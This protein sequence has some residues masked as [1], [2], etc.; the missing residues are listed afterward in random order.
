MDSDEDFLRD[1]DAS[2]KAVN[3]FASRMRRRG[4]CMWLPP[5]EVRPDSSVRADYS[6]NGD[7]ILQGRV[8]HKVRTIDFTTRDDYPFPTVIVDEKRIEDGKAEDPV[9][10]YVIEN[11]AGTHAAVVYGWTKPRW[12][13]MTRFDRLRDRERT[14]YVVSKSLVRFCP[15]D[16]VF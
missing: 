11:K 12:Q 2:A 7:L 9:I 6:D 1:F 15:V 5:T 10:A 4:V 3:K 8:E 14:F 13:T 16:E